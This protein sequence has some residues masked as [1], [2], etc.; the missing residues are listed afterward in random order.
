MLCPAL[1][2]YLVNPDGTLKKV[3]M[4]SPEQEDRSV[5][6]QGERVLVGKVNKL[7]ASLPPQKC[8]IC[9]DHSTV[10]S[11]LGCGHTFC[12]ECYSTFLE[13]KIADEGHSCIFARCPHGK[14][15][16]LMS[17]QLVRSLLPEGEKLQQWRRA[18]LLER[19][20]VDENPNIKWC[21][22]SDCTCAIKAS[23]GQLSVMCLRKHRFCFSCM[24]DD[25]RPCACDDL[26]RWLIKCKDDSET[27]NWLMSNTK[28]CPK[29]CTSIEK[30]GGCNHITC[31]NGSCKHEWCWVCLGP[32][33]DHSGSYY[34]CNK[35]DPDTVRKDEVEDKKD[36]SRAALERYLHYYTRFTNHDQSLNMETEA[37]IKTEAKVKEMEKQGSNTWMD[38]QYLVEANEALHECRYA[39]RYTYVYAFYLD[40]SSNLKEVPS[41]RNWRPV[42]N[43][44]T[45][46][47]SYSQANF[48]MQQSELERQTEELAGLLERDVKDI[49]RTEVV[50]CF[51][52]AKKRL[53]NLFEI[54]DM[55]KEKD[56]NGQG[57]S[58]D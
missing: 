48:E 21:P 25:H 1:A 58:T 31:K 39:L 3:G 41:I 56:N 2:E 22:A 17:D 27:Y 28:T 29:C 26:K 14:C 52:M 38:C 55:E 53:A 23:K 37:K 40:K 35:Y 8:M 44:L 12:N 5:I 33:K 18:A 20:F 47:S 43:R 24:L 51:Q 36:N 57:S 16:L 45:P 50:H 9:Y 15:N 34:A 10:Y 42:E 54:V 46:C 13:H 11:A 4:M 30:N 32:W 7:Q 6:H 19:S 49:Q